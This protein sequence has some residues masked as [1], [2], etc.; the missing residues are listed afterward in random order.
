M[1]IENK[2]ILKDHVVL[3]EGVDAQFFL[4][5]LLDTLK[6]NNIQ[7]LDFHGVYDLTG[8]LELFRNWPGY[9]RVKSII[10]ARDAEESASSAIQ[11]VNGSLQKAGL[12]E[13]DIA[14]FKISGKDIKV[15]I[16]LFPGLDDAGELCTMGT[17]E[18]LCIKLF[19][20]QEVA[21]C[22]NT[23]TD[24]FQEKCSIKFKRPHKNKLH[25]ML[26]LT[27]DYVGLKI[28]ETAKSRGFNFDSLYLKPYVDILN[29]INRLESAP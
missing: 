24:D 15:G 16:M 26:S 12:I 1:A 25:A 19:K 8:Y 27:D 6:F 28:G 5:Y 7:V 2:K 29:E 18:D 23:Y 10:I 11:S 14:A 17:L 21:I 22:A 4:I 20:F 9:N 13:S 3:A